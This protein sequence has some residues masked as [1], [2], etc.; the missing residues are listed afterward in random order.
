VRPVPPPSTAQL[1]SHV[2]NLARIQAN[3]LQR[4]FSGGMLS[5]QSQFCP[6]AK[7]SSPMLVGLLVSGKSIGGWSSSVSVG[8]SDFVHDGVESR[9]EFARS[10]GSLTQAFLSMQ[11]GRQPPTTVLNEKGAE[12]AGG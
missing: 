3:L 7:P 6:W 5:T 1:P 4:N 10:K 2:V 12:H 9:G 8:R 11:Y